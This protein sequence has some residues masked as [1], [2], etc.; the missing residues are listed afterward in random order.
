MR[1]PRKKHKVKEWVSL[2]NLI[3]QHTW[4]AHLLL[5]RQQGLLFVFWPR[6]GNDGAWAAFSTIHTSHPSWS[7]SPPPP[8]THSVATYRSIE[9]PFAIHGHE[10][11]TSN[12]KYAH[13]SSFHG[14]DFQQTYRGDIGIRETKGCAQECVVPMLPSPRSSHSRRGMDP[15]AQ[16]PLWVATEPQPHAQRAPLCPMLGPLSF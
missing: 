6:R 10:E 14:G 4:A 7:W 2:Q 5:T 11:S 8:D 9:F 13:H 1:E 12:T 16:A 3:K 15:H